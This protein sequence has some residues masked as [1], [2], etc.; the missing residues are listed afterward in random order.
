V[1]SLRQVLTSGLSDRPHPLYAGAVALVMRDGVIDSHEA[2]GYAVRYADSEGTLLP[3]AQQVEMRPDTIFDLAS[4]TK[5]FTTS[6][7]LRLVDA[8]S[9]ALDAPIHP[10]LPSF[11]SGIRRSVS[12]RHLLTHTSGLP[13]LLNLWTDWPDV[14]ARRSAVLDAPLERSPGAAFSYSDIGYMVAGFLAEAVTGR[15]LADLVLEWVCAPLGMSDTGF[16]PSPEV[17]ARIAAT[18]DESYAGRG[19]V[20][21]SVHDENAWALGGAVG[22]AGIFSTATD[23]A[24][25]GEALRSGGAV[26]GT[27]I[28][29][30]STVEE[31]MRDQ[32]PDWLDPGFRQGLGLRIADPV[33]MGALSGPR[34]VG[35]TGFTGTSL[36]IDR[37]GGCMVVLLTN[38]VHPSRT[39]SD[40]GVMRRRVAAIA[41]SGRPNASNASPRGRSRSGSPERDRGPRHRPEAGRGLL[42]RIRAELPGLR[43]A[44]RRVAVAVLEDPAGVAQRSIGAL[45]RECDTSGAT[46]LR[47]CRAVGYTHYPDLRIDLARETSREEA[48]NGP[49]PLLTGDISAIDTL[50]EIVAKIAWS[51]ARAIE[52]T[53][54]TLDVETLG[55][56][57]DAVTAATRVDIYGIG[58]SGF[59]AQDLHQK[60]HRIGLL[61][62]VWPDPHA[63]LTSAALLGPPDVA[64]AISHTGTTIDTIE[65][66][67][68]AQGRGATTIA[69]T[70]F[71]DSPL[72]GQAH[73]VLTTAARETTFRSGA[74][75]SRIA[76]LAVVDCL[77]V[78][79][80]QRSYERTMLALERTFAAVQGR[81][82]TPVRSRK[83]RSVPG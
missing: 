54:A 67:R 61:S 20:R 10:W 48:D 80:A 2:V 43:P 9:I 49:G 21:G 47:F 57:I 79:V 52:D 28:L 53:A 34:T 46:V 36:L 69:I 24:R 31:M 14:P 41:V 3:D 71:G 45:A 75:A 40:V 23:L 66:L 56:A 33:S 18:E 30:E 17:E 78:G 7:L 25:L 15:S 50:S 22:H 32:L 4:L 44:E 42:V 77:F 63:A 29:A 60:L 13:A 35:H 58:A 26:D 72:A 38:R 68:V 65:A 19:M 59:V 6:V 83:R 16:L 5:L 70:N 1:A 8:G 62:S 64:I 27:R 55:R 39:W 12:L 51:D 82:T 81:R 74:M 11:A 73:H 76:Q 37:D